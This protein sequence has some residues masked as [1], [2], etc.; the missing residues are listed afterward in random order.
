MAGQNKLRNYDINV[1]HDKFLDEIHRQAEF[2]Y[3]LD[4]FAIGDQYNEKKF[5]HAI[6]F[7]K[8]TCTDL[9]EVINQV[10]DTINE[11]L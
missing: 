10:K 6:L 8:Y 3:V 2:K 7:E 11:G 4:Y 1:I 9:C 5:L